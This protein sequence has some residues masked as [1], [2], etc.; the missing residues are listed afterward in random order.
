[1]ANISK[2]ILLLLGLL[3]SFYSCRNSKKWPQYLNN[4]PQT[5]EYNYI[6][7]E[8]WDSE[9]AI[10]T[11][12]A[13]LWYNPEDKNNA[14]FSTPTDLVKVK[15]KYWI[16]DPM[17]GG[18]FEF[19]PEG[20]FIRTITPR[21]RGP[22]ETSKPSAMVTLKEK[23]KVHTYVVDPA[24]KSVLVFDRA[25]NEVQRITHE[26]IDRS[27]FS[28]WMIALNNNRLVWPTYSLKEH[29]VVEADTNGTVRR[30]FIDRLIPMGSQPATHNAVV[31][32]ADASGNE[33]YAYRGLP[34]LFLKNADKKIIIN[35]LPNSSL[36]SI[37]VPLEVLP[38]HNQVSVKMLIKDIYSYENE[39]F[40]HFRN[41]LVVTN[42]NGSRVEG[43]AI[44]DRSNQV[45]TPQKI[46]LAGDSLFFIDRFN[47]KIYKLPVDNI[48]NS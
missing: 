38:G 45:I 24:Q 14:V 48:L 6:E 37:N 21:G 23:N 32:D 41:K 22:S 25:G 16:C 17:V 3:L 46:V 5:Q 13:T 2:N 12:S 1:M 35:L 27:Q 26:T 8:E 4:I 33:F 30:S 20:D 31:Y 19:G 29:V 44:V 15:D 40:I 28:N 47:L 34:V 9:G 39:I 42:P 43:F 36:E 18:V 7:A 10:D 11:L